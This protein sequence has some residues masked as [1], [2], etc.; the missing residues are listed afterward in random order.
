MNNDQLYDRLGVLIKS[1]RKQL[2]LTQQK[3]AAR[4]GISRASLAN[5]ET[6]RQKV[7]VHQLYAFGTAL[8]LP[9]SDLLPPPTD[10]ELDGDWAALP[11]PDGLKP[12]QK[13][14]IAR[15]LDGA[16]L[17]THQRKEENNAK[18]PKQ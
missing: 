13:R 4:L 1:R 7:L 6:G 2:S 17:D 11:M 16:Q 10:L 12:E 3:L 15:L 18:Q 14:Q 5:I 8:G 9:P